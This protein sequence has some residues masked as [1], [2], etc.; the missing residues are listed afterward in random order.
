M[1]LVSFFLKFIGLIIIV[2]IFFLS[3]VFIVRVCVKFVFVN[4]GI[5]LMYVEIKY[6]ILNDFEIS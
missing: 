2:L 3:C 6:I 4:W 1:G 5:V